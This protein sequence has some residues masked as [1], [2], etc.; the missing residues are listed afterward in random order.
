MHQAMRAVGMAGLLAVTG[1][2]VVVSLGIRGLLAMRVLAAAMGRQLWVSNGM[3]LADRRHHGAREQA[4]RHQHQQA[5]AEKLTQSADTFAHF[6]TITRLVA[7]HKRER[8]HASRYGV[9]LRSQAC[10][11]DPTSRRAGGHKKR[12]GRT[13]ALLERR[14]MSSGDADQSSAAW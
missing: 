1:S 4:K 10:G 9:A 11:R 5:G 3:H 8:M 13:R 14:A 7:S 12:P 2:T 6:C